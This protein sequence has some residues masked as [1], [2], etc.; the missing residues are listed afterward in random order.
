MKLAKELTKKEIEECALLPNK[1]PPENIADE[2]PLIR[3]EHAKVVKPLTPYQIYNVEHRLMCQAG[4]LASKVGRRYQVR[5]HS[6]RKFFRTQL[7]ALGMPTDYVEYMMG[8]AISTDH[9]V[10]M[11]GIEFLRAEYAKQD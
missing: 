5:P 4:L 6:L 3:D 9:N 1:I 10:E 8:H 11:N 2:S 7:S